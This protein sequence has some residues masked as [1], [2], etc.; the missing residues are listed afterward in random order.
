MEGCTHS[1]S[2]RLREPRILGSDVSWGTFREAYTVEILDPHPRRLQRI[3]DDGMY[4]L[5]V[6]S[7][8]VLREEA[9]SWGCDV[10]VPDVGQDSGGPI[11][12][13]FDDPRAEFIGRALQTKRNV[14][15]L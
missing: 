3:L 5:S 9:L 1:R 7:R 15:P 13:V 4:P 11:W 12:I 2:Y 6:V 10:R 14:R 8:G